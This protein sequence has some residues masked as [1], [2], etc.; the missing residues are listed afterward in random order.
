MRS[1]LRLKNRKSPV[2]LPTYIFDEVRHR[3]SRGELRPGDKILEGKIAE[4]LNVSRTPVREAMVELVKEG[5]LVFLPRKGT[6]VRQY[7]RRE[8]LEIYDV[9]EVLE[10][11]AARL[12]CEN[13]DDTLLQ[14]LERTNTTLKEI[15]E[16]LGRS[17]K[18]TRSILFGRFR[19][20]DIEFHR[21]MIGN[22]G[23][24]FLAE[25]FATIDFIIE[26]FVMTSEDQGMER[27]E[28]AVAEH[29]EIVEQLR[30]RSPESSEQAM[31]IHIRDAREHCYSK[32]YI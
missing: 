4:E 22:S 18:G 5:L 28:K 6:Y 26:S 10:G 25:K 14:H 30:N 23:N 16:E 24:S 1:E 32:T 17:P 12:V 13:H 9:R 20:L 19:E 7:S 21:T 15:S 11:L 27:F 2:N 8:Y 3:I 29:E 31:R